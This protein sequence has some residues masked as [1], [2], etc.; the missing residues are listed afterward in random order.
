MTILVGLL[1]MGSTVAISLVAQDYFLG[2]LV[3]PINPHIN[4][5]NQSPAV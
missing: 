4:H 5:I 3:E 2:E 1:F